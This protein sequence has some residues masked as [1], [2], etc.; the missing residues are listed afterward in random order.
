MLIALLAILAWYAGLAVL[1][2]IGTVTISRLRFSARFEQIFF[3]LILI[4][5]AGMY[6]VFEAYFDN[7]AAFRTELYAV[8]CF[9]ALGLAGLRLPSLLILGYVLHGAWDLA[10]E[11]SAQISPSSGLLGNFTAIPLAYGVFCATFDW[12]MGAYFVTRLAAWREA[13]NLPG[14][15]S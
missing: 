10:H 8:L 1:A 3:A 6:L 5:I 9:A 13:R 4:P 12:A 7:G 14:P 15:V 2:A 11:I